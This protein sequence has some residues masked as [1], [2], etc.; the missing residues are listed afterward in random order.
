VVYSSLLTAV[1]WF[2][3]FSEKQK[4]QANVSISIY[5]HSCMHAQN[6]L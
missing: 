1:C 5:A 2:E 6:V 4:E 3:E